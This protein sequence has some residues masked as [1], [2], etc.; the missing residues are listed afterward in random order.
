MKI[1]HISDIHYDES[2]SKKDELKYSKFG[3]NIISF[4]LLFETY[5]TF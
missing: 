1:A 5:L 3:I 4:F 2:I